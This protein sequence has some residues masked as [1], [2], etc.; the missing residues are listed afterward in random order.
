[1]TELEM[2][3]NMERI[4]K[5]MVMISLEALSWYFPGETEEPQIPP[6]TILTRYQPNSSQKCYPLSH[7]L[8]SK[9]LNARD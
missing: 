5:E 7:L 1:M 4:Q 3:T 6:A 2:K 8:G 9:K